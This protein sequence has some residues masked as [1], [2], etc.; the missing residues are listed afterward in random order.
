MPATS[1]K[2]IGF[3][4]NNRLPAA[5]FFIDYEQRVKK[6]P[7]VSLF[8]SLEGNLDVFKGSLISSPNRVKH[9]FNFV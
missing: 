8:P 9:S 2:K 6:Q 5:I 7:H 1:N 3:I 4:K